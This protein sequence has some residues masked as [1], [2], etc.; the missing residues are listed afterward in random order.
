MGVNLCSN[1]NE[2]QNCIAYWQGASM[3]PVAL[4]LFI[5]AI[6]SISGCASTGAGLSPLRF[7][8]PNVDI[9]DGLKTRLGAI[10]LVDR[11]IVAYRSAQN[12]NADARQAFEVPA[13]VAT[14]GAVAATAFG[15]GPDAVLAGGTANAIFKGGNA[16][17]APKA[18]AAMFG[19]AHN[20]MTCVQAVATGAK[21]YEVETLTAKIAVRGGQ[22]ED[23]TIYY[24]IRNGALSIDEIL[25][26]RLS[27]AGSVTDAAGIAA[28][29]EAS[30]KK[31]LEARAAAEKA[32]KDADAARSNKAIFGFDATTAGADED[33]AQRAAMI[34]ELQEKV[35]QCVL[36]A[37]T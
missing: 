14:I 16:Y 25:R 24:L 36:R 20:A 6:P 15:G 22:A 7:S 1:I 4:S 33:A 32:K 29:Y 26:T 8:P 30:V 31:E 37:K 18:K 28:E 21:P 19:S 27:N 5:I 13:F 12:A 11:F 9:S 2:S 23:P 35:Q 10:T 17:Y 3:R 34:T